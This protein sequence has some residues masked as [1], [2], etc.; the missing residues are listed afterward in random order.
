M[1][2]LLVSKRFGKILFC[3]AINLLL[4]T[5][6]GYGEFKDKWEFPGGKIEAGESDEEA[7]TREIKEELNASITP[8]R[9]IQTIEWDY[10]TFHLVM[11]V[12]LCHLNNPHLEL[13]EAENAKWLD[14]SDIDSVDWL[15]ADRLLLPKLKEL[16]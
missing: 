6:R 8:D 4:G 9:F 15:P 14:R 12:Y 7:L 13:L 11:N 3:P 10:P 2:T 1:K 5:Q 16:I